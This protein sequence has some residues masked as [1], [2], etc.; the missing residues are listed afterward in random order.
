MRACVYPFAL[1][2]AASLAACHPGEPDARGPSNAGASAGNA[3]A[4]AGNSAQQQPNA[5]LNGGLGA[6]SG[7]GLT[8][9]FPDRGASGANASGEAAG[10]DGSRNRTTKGSVGN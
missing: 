10:G 2:M 4:S 9:S 6:S 1:A 8:G 7:T 5:R 3:T